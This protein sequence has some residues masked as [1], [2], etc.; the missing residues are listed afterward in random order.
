MKRIMKK[1]INWKNKI[2][3]GL[4]ILSL[5]YLGV[6]YINLKSKYNKLYVQESAYRFLYKKW[7]LLYFES[8]WLHKERS[9]RMLFHKKIKMIKKKR[10]EHPLIYSLNDSIPNIKIN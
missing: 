10:R 6:E 7:K 9:N 8:K 1:N 2:T 5:A 3:T 4:L